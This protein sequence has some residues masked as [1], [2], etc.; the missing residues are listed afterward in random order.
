MKIL[1]SSPTEKFLLKLER[2]PLCIVAYTL[3]KARLSSVCNHLFDLFQELFVSTSLVVM[4][5][6]VSM[7]SQNQERAPIT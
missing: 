3:F 1:L 6:P 4:T 2:P 5:V 7:V